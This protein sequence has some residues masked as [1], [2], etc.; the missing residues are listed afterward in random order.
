MNPAIRLGASSQWA[1]PSWSEEREEFE[2]VAAS[3]GLDVRKLRAAFDRGRLIPLSDADW[4][5]LENTD[6]GP[7]LT[8]V[9]ARRLALEYERDLDSMMDAMRDGEQLPAPI[10]LQKHDGSLTLVAG[11]TRLMVARLLG[12]RP[13]VLFIQLGR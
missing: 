10:V 4:S 2:R 3:D 1:M 11:N 12:V 8:S 9:A 13:T 6:S 7:G 5:R